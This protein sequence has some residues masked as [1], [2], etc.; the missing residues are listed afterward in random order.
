MSQ[1]K[2]ISLAKDAVL[3]QSVADD[4]VHCAAFAAIDQDVLRKILKTGRLLRI[5]AKEML[6]QQ[7]GKDSSLFILISGSIQI[8]SDGNLVSRLHNPGDIVGEM[9]IFAAFRTANVLAETDVQMVEIPARVFR[10]IEEKADNLPTSIS[11]EVYRII[12]ASLAT[13]LIKSNQQRECYEGAVREMQGGIQEGRL[14]TED[15]LRELLLHSQTVETAPIPII[16]TTPSGGF[17]KLNRAAQSFLKRV[18]ASPGK[19]M[20]ITSL[21]AHFDVGPFRLESILADASWQGEW[22]AK[23]SPLHYRV[24]ASSVRD[25]KNVMIAAAYIFMDVSVQNKQAKDIAHK[26]QAI[27]RALQDLES[28]YQEL[29][30]SDQVK[31]EMLGLI[32]A[33]MRPPVVQVLNLAEII[34]AKIKGQADEVQEVLKEM[35]HHLRVLKLVSDNIDHLNELQAEFI[36]LNE[37]NIDLQEVIET[38]LTAMEH[39]QTAGK[40][41]LKLTTDLSPIRVHWK[42]GQ[43]EKTIGILV[44][45]ALAISHP[46]SFVRVK[47]VQEKEAQFVDIRISYRGVALDDKEAMKKSLLMNSTRQ[48]AIPLVRRNVLQNHGVLDFSTQGDNAH[49]VLRLPVIDHEDALEI[50]SRILIYDESEADQLI[51]SGLAKNIWPDSHCIVAAT[52]YELLSRYE[53]FVPDLVIIDPLIAEKGWHSHRLLT[54]LAQNRHHICPVLSISTLYQDF[55]ERDIAMRRGV[56][57][58]LPKPYSI[59]DVHFKIRTMVERHKHEISLHHTMNMANKQAHTDGLTKLANRKYFDDFLDI[60]TAYSEQTGKPCSLIMLDVDNFKHFNDNHGHQRGD[61][62]LRILSRVMVDSVRSSDLAARYG[63]EEFVIVLP[64]TPKSMARVIAEKVRKAIS[65]ID[66]PEGEQQPLGLISASLGVA[67]FPEDSTSSEELIQNADK[68]MY[69]AKG[70][71]RNRV[72]VYPPD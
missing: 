20:N 11:R 56:N 57:D 50:P 33:E 40:S 58:F 22:H 7:G 63:G 18:G 54:S 72:I 31:S 59:S 14:S 24:T 15:T 12:A 70:H 6:I 49:I 2:A 10:D 38:I 66:M 55:A 37:Q 44:E 25:A 52:P 19:A 13:K 16:L 5:A 64:E 3:L 45:E 1:T 34:R 48:V 53:V 51:L 39:W 28:T 43:L 41:R 36:H 67:A 17:I 27:Q 69:H 42:S 4:I 61:A 46:R 23:T 21:V 9:R 30:R 35:Q 32:A 68:A 8:I 60:Q 29:Q 65:A 62:L 71:G 47:V 26:T